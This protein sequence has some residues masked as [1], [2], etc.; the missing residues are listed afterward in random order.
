M[1]IAALTFSLHTCFGA[2]PKNYDAIVYSTTQHR[3]KGILEN[4][5]DKGVT[6]DYF[7]VSKFIDAD[8]IRIIKIKRSSALKS[9]AFTGAAAGLLVGI[10]IYIDGNNKGKLSSLALPVVLIGTTLTGAAF[11]SAINSL[12][13]VRKYEIK[14][15]TPFKSIHPILLRYS[16][17]SPSKLSHKN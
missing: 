9:H 3:Y 15:D 6:I 16:K 17:A 12:T 11:V 5:T 7:G 4:V 8:S 1:S 10:P 13:H 2:K 14:R